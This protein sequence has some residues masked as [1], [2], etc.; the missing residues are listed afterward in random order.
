MPNTKLEHGARNTNTMSADLPN[1]MQTPVWGPCLWTYLHIWSLHFPVKPTM[2]TRL[3]M[4]KTLLAILATLPCNL[5][6]DNAGNN[7]E[8]VGFSRPH[9][10]QRLAKTKFMESRKTFTRFIFD[11][12]NQVSTMLGKDTSHIQY[13]QVMADL[14]MGRAKGCTKKRKA[15]TMDG[16]LETP[17]TGCVQPMYKACK[18]VIYIVPRTPLEG[19]QSDGL[20]TNLNMDDRLV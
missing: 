15:S 14:E 10:P 3:A 12:H 20:S 4:A 9:T 1:S 17:E 19:G 8:K 16:S 6:V 2:G 5:C 13:D 11:L 7:L 18:T